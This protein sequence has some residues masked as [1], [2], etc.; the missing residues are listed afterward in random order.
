MI[1]MIE[2][3][4]T[5]R[6]CNG[7]ADAHQQIVLFLI[8]T[9]RSDVDHGDRHRDYSML[10]GGDKAHGNTAQVLIADGDVVASRDIDRHGALPS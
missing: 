9:A 8:T 4:E 5:Q 1:T 2:S 6:G 7:L 3:L 10:V